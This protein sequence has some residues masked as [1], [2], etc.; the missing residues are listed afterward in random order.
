[1]AYFIWVK[2]TGGTTYESSTQTF[3]ILLDTEP[4]EIQDET[5]SL[6]FLNQTF[7][8][9]ATLLDNA[10]VSTAWITYW[11]DNNPS[12]NESM[13][14]NI[15]NQWTKTITIPSSVNQLNY[16]IATNDTSNNW[17]SSILTTV[18]IIEGQ[19]I[20]DI[21]QSFHDRGFPIRHAADGDWAGAQNYIPSVS[22]ISSVQIYLRKC[23]R[24]LLWSKK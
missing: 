11:F 20:L 3:S 24:C 14:Y 22:I 19:I 21:N 8:F 23:F 7:T 18:S 4:P 1:M 2:D 9:S 12:I 6:G 10:A 17:N 13:S 16:T 15:N 5:P